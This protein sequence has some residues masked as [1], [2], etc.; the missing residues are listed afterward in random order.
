MAEMFLTPIIHSLIDLL[1]DEVGSIKGIRKKVESLKRE[2]DIIQALLKDADAKANRE[3]LISDAMKV[4]MKQLREE[5]DHINDVIDEYR[6]HVVQGTTE[7]CGLN[8]FLLKIG[9]PIKALKSRYTISSQ[10]EDI[11][12]SLRQIKDVGQ[13]FGLSRSLQGSGDKTWWREEHGDR[14]GAHFVEEDE[15]YV[16]IPL[17]QGQLKS[18]LLEGESARMIISLVG[19]GLITPLRQH[20]ETKRYVVIFDDVWDTNFW[21][22][23]K[24][25]LPGNDNGSRVIIT[26]RNEVV[27]PCDFVQKLETWSHDMAYELFSKKILGR[28]FKCLCPEELEKL[29]HKIIQKCQGLPLAI[30]AIAGLLSRKNV[31]S[32]WQKVLDNIDFEFKTNS[33]LTR[34]FQILSLSYHDLPYHLKPCFLYFGIFPED[35]LIEKNKLC[36]LWISEGFVQ[37]RESKTA[38]EEAEGYINELVER[39][40]VCFEILH[41]TVKGCKVHDLMHEFI[42]SKF[43]G[44]RSILLLNI[45]GIELID[46][47]FWI[48][49]FKSSKLLKVLDFENAPLDYLPKEVGNL[50]QLRY[51]NLKDTNIKV[52]PES[53]CNL[54]DLQYLNLENTQVDKLPK[55]IGKLRNLRFLNILYAF[56]WEL[57]LEIN[58][59]CN[60]RQ[61]FAS[62]KEDTQA[63]LSAVKIQE[64]FSYL[65]NLEILMHVEVHQDV[66]GFINELKNLSNLKMLGVSNLTKETSR[67]ICDVSK[68]LNHLHTLILSVGDVDE[69][70]DLEPISSS[71]PPLL[72]TLYLSGQL[73]KFPH[74]LLDFN[75]LMMLALRLSKLTQNPLKYLKDLP[76]LICLLLI[77]NSY[78]GEQ[79][80]FEEGSFPK[81]NEIRFRNL[82][83][84][85]FMKIDK[86]ALPLLKVLIIESCPLIEEVPSGIQYLTKLK[87]LCIWN[88]P[89]P[90]VDRVLSN[91]GTDYS[92]I[93]HIPIVDII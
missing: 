85:K 45:N 4:W 31:Q 49:L 19:Q 92:K 26:T 80:H 27:A 43:T 65:E 66:I 50:F 16:D 52:L 42:I 68:R 28:D 59:L 24:Y 30:R 79:L 34:I 35:Y 57:P 91:E 10:I 61:V 8:G 38:E 51:L 62:R 87:K 39:S 11:I 86:G 54:H 83:E 13:G 33:Q 75:N 60:L 78:E 69:I 1:K 23:M 70:L 17:F 5:A 47:S 37:A 72:H 44:V 74:C 32:E 93:Q 15:E 71:P 46:K 63:N 82:P 18:F 90:F 55:S 22:K 89:K 77:D 84:L 25:A 2:L 6:W 48:A 9:G 64:G 58:K 41:G 73:N 14:F 56:V 36:R 20:L 76:N 12:Q 81:L 3:D 29:S 7:K 88:M 67:A 21:E 40:L 53:I